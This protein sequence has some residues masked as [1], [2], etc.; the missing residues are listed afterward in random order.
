MG[1]RCVDSRRSV[2]L[3]DEVRLSERGT[4]GGRDIPHGSTQLF[5]SHA[6]VI[7]QLAP[8]SGQVLTLDDAKDSF[9]DVLPAYHRRAVFGVVQQIADELP[10]FAVAAV[11][12]ASPAATAVDPGRPPRGSPHPFWLSFLRLDLVNI[13]WCPS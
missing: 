1:W 6:R 9:L 10:E 13:R 7:L 2:R 12:L 5:V 4:V 11:G 3:Q 8:E